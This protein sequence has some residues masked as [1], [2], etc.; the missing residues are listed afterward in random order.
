MG[1]RERWR[2][3]ALEVL[4][5]EEVEEID[6]DIPVALLSLF[7]ANDN[8][9]IRGKIML[10][11][12]AFIIG[13]E[14]IPELSESMHFFPYQWGPYSNIVAKTINTLIQLGL[15]SDKK[16]GRDDVF[17]LT[18]DGVEAAKDAAKLLPEDVLDDISKMKHT[19]QEVGLK[20]LLRF[21]YSNYPQYA[22]QSRGKAVYADT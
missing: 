2:N 5:V 3:N 21:I 1:F 9:P 8:S 12:Q 20:R 6:P 16:K 10:I 22:T 17:Y 19:T 13:K 14:I 11:K 7:L 15:V 18:S 4:S